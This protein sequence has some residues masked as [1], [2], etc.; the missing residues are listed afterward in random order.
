MGVLFAEWQD[1]RDLRQALRARD[2]SGDCETDAEAD[3]QWEQV[4][5]FGNEKG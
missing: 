1:A 5:E 4:S 2:C 3:A